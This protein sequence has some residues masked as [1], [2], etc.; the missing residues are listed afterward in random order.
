[1]LL[2]I[3]HGTGNAFMISSLLPV[4]LFDFDGAF[5]YQCGESARAAIQEQ[6]E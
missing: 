6:Q 4:H 2:Y 5:R 3:Y 1:M